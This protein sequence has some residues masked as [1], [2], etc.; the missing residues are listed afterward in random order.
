MAIEV[1]EA[2]KA[3][4]HNGSKTWVKVSGEASKEVI[5]VLD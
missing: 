4:W 5:V 3:N 2:K 1:D